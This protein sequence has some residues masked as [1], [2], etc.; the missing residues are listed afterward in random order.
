[1]IAS[2][3]FL[4]SILWSTGTSSFP[5]WRRHCNLLAG[6]A[7][8]M[9]RLLVLNYVRKIKALLML[10]S[11]SI[12]V[13][14]FMLVL[15]IK[16]KSRNLSWALVKPV[17]S[18]NWSLNWRSDS[19]WFHIHIKYALSQRETKVPKNRTDFISQVVFDL[20]KMGS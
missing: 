12:N 17:N 16:C 14:R 15:M 6:R 8:C 10:C 2:F 4:W 19:S 9:K 1:M 7:R 5:L 18:Y 20:S 13:M 11:F 3:Y